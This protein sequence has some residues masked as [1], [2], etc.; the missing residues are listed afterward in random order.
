MR[1]PTSWLA[2]FVTLPSSTEALADVLTFAGFEV[3]AI[4]RPSA[5]ACGVTV[6]EVE[7]V[8]ALPGS[9][10]LSFVQAVDGADRYGIVC[11]ASNFAVGDRVPA[12]LPGAV[13]PSGLEVERREIFG[14]TS[15]GMLASPAELGVGDDGSRIWVLDADAPLGADLTEWLNLDEAV[16]DLEITPDRGYALSIIGLARDVAALTGAELALPAAD[17]PTGDPGVPV[18]LHDVERC[19]RFDARRFS[20]VAVGPSPAWMQRRLAA[21]GLRPVSNVVDATNY[22]MLETGNPV[23]AYDAHRLAGPRLEVRTAAAGETLTTLDGQSRSLHPDDLVIADAEGPV[24]L[25]GV[26]GGQASEIAETTTEVLLEVANFAADSVLRTARRHGLHTEG[27]ARWEK[28]VPPE[29]VTLAATRCAALVTAAAG[30]EM[31]GGAD[32]YP[33]PPEPAPITLRPVRARGHLGM[34]VTDAR[35][36]ELL[37]AIGCEVVTVSQPEPDGDEQAK[38]GGD[39]QAKPGGDSRAKPG[40]D[41]A[42][43]A[44]WAVTAPAYRVDLTEEADLY[45]EIARLEGYDKVPETT[46]SSG[47][48]GGRSPE[49]EARRTVRRAVAGGGWSEVVASPFLADADLAALGVPADDRRR[50]PLSLTNPLSAEQSV[51]R[52][53]LIPGLTRLT[54]HN[55]NHGVAD[56]AIFEV[57]HVF[58]APTADEPGAAGGPAEAVLPAEPLML[59]FAGC[60]HFEPAR[61]DRAGRGADLYDVLGAADL[62]RA[63]VGRSALDAAPTDEAPFHP[64]RAARLSVEGR[65]LGAVGELHPRVI[66]AFALPART[67]AGEVRLDRLVAGGAAQATAPTPSPL[68]GL[69]LD[70][71]V[72]VDEAVPAAA[73]QDAV[74][75]GAG[76]RLTSCVLF[77]VFRGAQ[78]GEGNK[79]L[80][81]GLRIDD[82]TQQLSESDEQA[83]IAGIEEAIAERVNG[84]LRR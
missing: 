33:N 3:G 50:R 22:A 7:S 60:G 75:A 65:D 62:A 63:A 58:L 34:A 37:E 28:T 67:L 17:E 45:E 44:R 14:A 51:L 52:T 20:G 48:V 47:V 39:S 12:V 57:G 11:G 73:V 15:H 68:P 27:S 10:K 35:Q 43:T 55:V 38:P 4:E 54:R 1:V 71:A 66:E 9:D 59:G 64:G 61:H 76:D 23:H 40:G 69:R 72:V 25:A 79:S 78:I 83:A 21:A 31:V 84:R 13:L 8:E 24:A 80:A 74:R 2:E 77:D 18:E 36:R 70:V 5:G 56:V 49:D 42:G 41:E 19:R 82:P 32:H 30:G 53:S 81:Y 46:P 16:L 26:M 29:G 6:A